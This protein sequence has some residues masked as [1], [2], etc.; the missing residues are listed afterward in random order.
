M[1]GVGRRTS[2]YILLSNILFS[3]LGSR[4]TERAKR[5][6]SIR[7]SFFFLQRAQARL[8]P[9]SPRAPRDFPQHHTANR[10]GQQA[11]FCAC[12]IWGSKERVQHA[13]GANARRSGDAGRKT[14]TFL[15]QPGF[16]PQQALTRGRASASSGLHAFSPQWSPDRGVPR[17]SGPGAPAQGLGASHSGEGVPI[18]A[19]MPRLAP[20]MELR[21]RLRAR[22]CLFLS[23]SRPRD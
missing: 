8:S 5:A 7:S 18:R 23:F 4:K 13:R 16:S 11:Y 10:S 6:P 14:R 3:S 1:Q 15:G 9:C 17:G 2:H 21:R 22:V 19:G 20:Q 12:E